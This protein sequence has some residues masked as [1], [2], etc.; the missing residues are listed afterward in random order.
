MDA[1]VDSRS[2]MDAMGNARTDSS[3]SG[4]G[5][6]FQTGMMLTDKIETVGRWSHQGRIGK[7]TDAQHQTLIDRQ[8]HELTLGANYYL[9]KHF[10]KFQFD[11]G[12]RWG[13]WSDQKEYVGRLQLDASF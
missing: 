6:L 1:T 5:Y 11:L 8:A 9:N 12:L 7:T 10:F 4:W 3:R 2:G 13:Q